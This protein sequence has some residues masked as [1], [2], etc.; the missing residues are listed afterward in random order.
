MSLLP[1][2]EGL[3]PT[4]VADFADAGACLAALRRAGVTAVTTFADELCPVAARLAA[5][6]TGG[7]AAGDGWGRKDRQ[8]AIL[9][10]AG[11]SRIRSAPVGDARSLRAFAAAAGFPF[12]V[13]PVDGVGSR[14]AWILRTEADVGQFLRRSA[15]SAPA[16]SDPASGAMFAEE[17]IPG[18]RP[19]RPYLAD[20]VSAEV[21]RSGTPGAG[22]AS[23][24]T[25]RLVPSWPLRETGSVLP[26]SLPEHAQRLATRVAAR[27]LDALGAARGAFHVELKPGDPLPEIVEVNGRLG[28]FIA[29]LVRYGTGQDLG[30]AALACALGR[31]EEL[32]LSWRR[33]AL[34]L[35]FQPPAG[36]RRVSRAPGPREARRLPGV[37][38]VDAI[39]PEGTPVDWRAGSNEAAAKIWLT[40]DDHDEL[41]RRLTGMT[42]FLAS[43]FE[44]ADG[45][46]QAV[47]DTAWLEAV[48]RT[49]QL[50]E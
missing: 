37:V 20:W 29:R 8:R 16:S 35:L 48:S 34:V 32:S 3:A 25:D 23:F 21:F 41:H 12:V 19:P 14:D 49:S 36:A 33:C 5:G 30:R 9:R 11:V 50:G 7:P 18:T 28:G 6:L 42:Q 24:V 2:A 31:D 17:F 15:G 38:A 26:S 13:K 10:A 4:I 40:A 46:G 43:R 22:A 45:S 1:V 44:F 39:A 27:A 47:E